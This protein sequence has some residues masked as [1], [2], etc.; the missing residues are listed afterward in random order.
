MKRS[1]LSVLVFLISFLVVV[2]LILTVVVLA[3]APPRAAD[4]KVST[5]QRAT[6][7]GIPRI[8]L[9][10]YK[11]GIF[12][13]AYRAGPRNPAHSFTLID[14]GANKVGSRRL[15]GLTAAIIIGVFSVS[16]WAIIRLLT[17]SG[18]VLRL[19]F[20]MFYYIGTFVRGVFTDRAA[21]SGYRYRGKHLRQTGVF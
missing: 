7:S 21:L 6:F 9:L 10:H 12:R 1:Y 16:C 3:V 17:L 5:D 15:P 19:A 20:T 14:F 11:D 13:F 8:L 4:E 2:S 18:R